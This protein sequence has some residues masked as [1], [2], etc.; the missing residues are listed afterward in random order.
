MRLRFWPGFKAGKRRPGIAPSRPS[1]RRRAPLSNMTRK[2]TSKGL[3]L[4]A[5]A[6][7][8]L[9]EG[10]ERGSL[11][12]RA[13]EY[14]RKLR[15]QAKDQRVRRLEAEQMVTQLQRE[16]GDLRRRLADLQYAL[17]RRSTDEAH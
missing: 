10:L 8:E 6:F 2:R 15:N 3:R 17:D 7:G 13:P 5:P 16:N 4:P 14:I 12:Q 9:V 11:A 1:K